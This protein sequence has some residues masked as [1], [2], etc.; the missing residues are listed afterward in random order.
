MTQRDSIYV[1]K[2]NTSNIVSVKVAAPT[3]YE[4]SYATRISC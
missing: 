2:C 1:M 4:I 3:K